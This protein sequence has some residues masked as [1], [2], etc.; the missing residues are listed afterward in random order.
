[1]KSTES[2]YRLVI[3]LYREAIKGD[4]EMNIKERIYEARRQ[5]SMAITTTHVLNN[6]DKDL[7]TLKSDLE[8]LEGCI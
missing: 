8:Y 4:P 3:D 1:M 5:L 6:T 7:I 2:Y